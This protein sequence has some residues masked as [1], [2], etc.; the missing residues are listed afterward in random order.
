MIEDVRNTVRFL[1]SEPLLAVAVVTLGVAME[2]AAALNR[3]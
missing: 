2:P 3:E 1:L